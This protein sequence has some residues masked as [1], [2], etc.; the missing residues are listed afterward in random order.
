MASAS[1][2]RAEPEADGRRG[3]RTQG[4]SAWTIWSL[5]SGRQ[6]TVAEMYAGYMP[7]VTVSIRESSVSD[8]DS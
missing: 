7:M 6:D 8:N 5:P 1:E 2:A 4:G 3:E